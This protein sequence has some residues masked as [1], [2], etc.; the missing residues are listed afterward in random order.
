MID[1]VAINLKQ[2]GHIIISDM[3]VSPVNKEL[4]DIQIGF[5]IP[6]A[7]NEIL[8]SNLVIENHVIR[9]FIF[10]EDRNSI[11]SIG[12]SNYLQQLLSDV[13]Q[14]FISPLSFNEE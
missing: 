12:K 1:D 7:L 8:D 14:G 10:L 6:K 13:K 4:V 9:P 11:L 2:N 5:D 3:D